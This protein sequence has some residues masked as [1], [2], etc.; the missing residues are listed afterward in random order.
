VTIDPASRAE[1]LLALTTGELDGALNS[2]QHRFGHD[3]DLASLGGLDGLSELSRDLPQGWVVASRPDREFEDPRTTVDRPEPDALAAMVSDVRESPV[4]IR[5]YH[6]ELVPALRAV[7][8]AVAAPVRA[9]T[10]EGGVRDVNLALFLAPP[11]A[12]TS[13]HPDRHHNLLLQVAGT[14]DVW[15]EDATADLVGRHR[16]NVSYFRSPG[17][18]VPSLPTARLVRL[19]PGD[20]VYIPPT[21]FHWTRTTGDDGS[22]ALSIGFSTARTA[23]EAR[24]SQIDVSLHR[25]GW[26]RSRPVR[27]G[28]LLSRLK[29]RLINAT[30][31]ARGRPALIAPPAS[32]RDRG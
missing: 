4:S 32:T 5:L 8:S 28:G 14:K 27:S 9:L 31:V 3:V 11:G 20:G 19:G 24:V 18:G 6:L 10:A 30:D 15:I 12:V 22:V 26:R 1:T 29:V 23:G 25:L 7:T 17:D 16:R 13:A 2:P 21:S